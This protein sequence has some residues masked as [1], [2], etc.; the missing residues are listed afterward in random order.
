MPT[1]MDL[2]TDLVQ[3]MQRIDAAADAS[4]GE[5][6]DELAALLDDELVL[7]GEIKEKVKGYCYVMTEYEA[8][9]ERLYAEMT[10]LQAK[11][12]KMGVRK[13][14]AYNKRMK[15][16]E[17]LQYFMELHGLESID[18]DLFNPRI[19]GV[20]GSRRI[21]WLK[22]TEELP[23]EFKR[24]K[25]S[26]TC[27]VGEDI[28]GQQFIDTALKHLKFASVKDVFEPDTAKAQDAFKRGDEL[29]LE[30][31]EQEPPRKKLVIE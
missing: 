16:L 19:K 12:D 28:V 24:R 3:L 27:N 11:I 25:V 8:E 15:M 1:L 6:T 20:G 26:I 5:E 2:S 30:C 17:R 7:E 10:L 13:M 9:E 4:H 22:P 23:S 31:A 14:R 21:R 29:I 18:A